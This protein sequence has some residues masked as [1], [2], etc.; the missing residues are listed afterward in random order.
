MNFLL[1]LII[2]KF[3]KL[4]QNK[5]AIVMELLQLNCI[6][7]NIPK[8]VKVKPSNYIFRS[9][10]SMP[11]VNCCC[12]KPILSQT[13]EPVHVT[14]TVI[15]KFNAF[16][17]PKNLNSSSPNRGLVFQVGQLHAPHHQKLLFLFPFSVKNAIF[18]CTVELK[19]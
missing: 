16:L 1:I 5:L 13:H 3:C 2:W 8:Q 14:N 11:L 19:C 4:Y 18:C 15:V 9:Y 12:T 7:N 17:G 10:Q 6:H